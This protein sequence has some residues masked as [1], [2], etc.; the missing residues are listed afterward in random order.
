MLPKQQIPTNNKTREKSEQIRGLHTL[1]RPTLSSLL[2]DNLVA[3][4][5]MSLALFAAV[6]NPV[7]AMNK[8]RLY[9]YGKGTRTTFIH[10]V[11][12]LAAQPV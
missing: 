3:Q 7:E 10:R 5:R 9:K 8:K 12:P 4:T 6:N 2:H 11:P 1:N